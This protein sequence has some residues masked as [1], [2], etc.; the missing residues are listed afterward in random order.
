MIY[1]SFSR[2]PIKAPLIKGGWGDL[3]LPPRSSLSHR[4][5]ACQLFLTTDFRGSQR[6]KSPLSPPLLRE[7]RNS[8]PDHA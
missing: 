1:L 2:K 5:K 8:S 3:L 4:K 6:R 7:E